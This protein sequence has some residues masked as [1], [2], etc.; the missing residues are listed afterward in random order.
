MQVRNISRKILIFHILPLKSNINES[1][2]SIST[3]Q[4]SEVST[5]TEQRIGSFETKA[6]RQWTEVTGPL[7]RLLWG[8]K[9][10]DPKNVCMWGYPKYPDAGSFSSAII[11]S[12]MLP[13]KLSSLLLSRIKKIFQV[14]LQKS[15]ASPSLAYLRNV[16]ECDHVRLPISSQQKTTRYFLDNCDCFARLRKNSPPVSVVLKN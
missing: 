11:E 13:R 15:P 6:N 9:R 10:D 5:L 1:K 2:Q 16:K 8:G 4:T 3:W 14:Y 12:I 7:N